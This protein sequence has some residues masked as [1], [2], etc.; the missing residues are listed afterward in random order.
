[1]TLVPFAISY[2]DIVTF[3]KKCKKQKPVT[4]NCQVPRAMVL[5]QG[6]F[7][8]PTPFPGTFGN[9]CMCFWLA[10]LGDVAAPGI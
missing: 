2:S 5:N 10:Q 8:C 6:H 7:G 1:M 3:V 4:I 9:I